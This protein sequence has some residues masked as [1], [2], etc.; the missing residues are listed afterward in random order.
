MLPW[1]APSAFR[2]MILNSEDARDPE[3]NAE[4]AQQEETPAALK[5]RPRRAEEVADHASSSFPP[6]RRS[7]SSAWAA[8][9]SL[10]VT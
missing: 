5:L 3:R 8:C 6:W 4:K 1:N 9:S 7:R 10:W 2:L